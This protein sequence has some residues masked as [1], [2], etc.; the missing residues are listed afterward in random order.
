MPD[1]RAVSMKHERYLI[2]MIGHGFD[3]HTKLSNAHF[4][5]YIVRPDRGYPNQPNTRI[6]AKRYNFLVLLA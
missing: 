6:K 5:K 1:G 3:T 4:Y 2:F